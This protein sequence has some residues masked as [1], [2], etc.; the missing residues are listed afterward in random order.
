MPRGV[1][2]PQGVVQS[3]PKGCVA[4]G[5]L[6]QFHDDLGEDFFRGCGQIYKKIRDLP[7]SQ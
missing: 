4:P 6:L 5:G 3:V 1:F 2:G 7:L